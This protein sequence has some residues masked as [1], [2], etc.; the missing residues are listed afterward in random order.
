MANVIRQLG[1]LALASRLRRLGERLQR[2]ASRIYREQRL[3]FEAR[4]FPVAYLLSREPP[5]SVTAVADALGMTHPAVNQI[6][7]QMVRRGLLISRKDKDDER[8]RLL[9]LAPKGR[10]VVGELQPLWDAVEECTRRLI[11]EAGGDLLSGI[12]AIEKSLDRREMY[13]RIDS[14]LMRRQPAKMLCDRTAPRRYPCRSRVVIS[15]PTRKHTPKKK[16]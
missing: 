11:R 13:D 16:E 7:T 3:E 12:A 1:A 2:D 4:W 15:N 9:S 14:C 10:Q 6:A 5:M 8:R